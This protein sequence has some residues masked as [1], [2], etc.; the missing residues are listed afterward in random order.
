L[1]VAW[2]SPQIVI[3]VLEE[4][5]RTDQDVSSGTQKLVGFGP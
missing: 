4:S 5:A 1:V 3:G 2:V